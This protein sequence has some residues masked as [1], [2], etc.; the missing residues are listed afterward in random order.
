ME[1]GTLITSWAIFCIKFSN[2]FR[3]ITKSIKKTIETENEI[4]FKIKSR[5]SLEPLTLET[6]EL[7]G[8]TEER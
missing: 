5:Y 2:C 1:Q 6:M 4:T 8:N 3:L 7:L